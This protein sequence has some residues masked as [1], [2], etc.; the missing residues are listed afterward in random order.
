MLVARAQTRG[1]QLSTTWSNYP[2]ETDTLGKLRPTRHTTPTLE[3]QVSE[4]LRR[5]RM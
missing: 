1:Q 5:H 3:R 4:T 2:L